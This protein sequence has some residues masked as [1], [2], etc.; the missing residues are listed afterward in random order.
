MNQICKAR[1]TEKY[2][3]EERHC[4]SPTHRSLL[5][6]VQLP[7]LVEWY[8]IANKSPI[9]VFPRSRKTCLHNRPTS[10]EINEQIYKRKRRAPHMVRRMSTWHGWIM[11]EWWRLAYAEIW[12]SVTHSLGVAA[13]RE[14]VCSTLCTRW[15]YLFANCWQELTRVCRNSNVDNLFEF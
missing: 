14:F 3:S 12:L 13:H 1:E 8:I 10:A 2:L 15:H 4:Q 5:H 7:Q 6:S 11:H 9:L